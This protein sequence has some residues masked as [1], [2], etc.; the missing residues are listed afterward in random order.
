[1]VRVVCGWFDDSLSIAACR[2]YLRSFL[3]MTRNVAIEE[4]H[5]CTLAASDKG[6]TV[7]S[8]HPCCKA[9]CNCAGIWYGAFGSAKRQLVLRIDLLSQA[10]SSSADVEQQNCIEAFQKCPPALHME[11]RDTSTGNIVHSEF[12]SQAQ[13]QWIW[14]V[15]DEGAVLP[16]RGWWR[17]SF[18]PD[19]E[20][21]TSSTL[22]Y[23]CVEIATHNRV[24]SAPFEVRTKPSEWVLVNGLPSGVDQP[25]ALSA[26]LTACASHGTSKVAQGLD[27]KQVVAVKGP[28]SALFVKLKSRAQAGAVVLGAHALRAVRAQ[29][30]HSAAPPLQSEVLQR[31]LLAP[32]DHTQQPSAFPAASAWSPSGAVLVSHI[33]SMNTAC[34]EDPSLSSIPV[35]ACSERVNIRR[36]YSSASPLGLPSVAKMPVPQLDGPA[37]SPAAL[38]RRPSEDTCSE[39]EGIETG[40]GACHSDDAATASACGGTSSEGWD[41]DACSVSYWDQVAQQLDMQARSTELQ[42]D[43]DEDVVLPAAVAPL[44]PMASLPALP[45]VSSP[46]GACACCRARGVKRVRD[47]D[48]V[49]SVGKASKKRASLNFDLVHSLPRVEDVLGNDHS[50][51]TLVGD[52]LSNA[53]GRPW[54]FHF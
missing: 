18:R 29:Q 19:P 16:A 54:S 45:V 3:L 28:S 37:Q 15:G 25:A 32:S 13:M 44:P 7:R 50:A 39:P 11:Y 27:V 48:D 24:T 26:L 52:E 20:R 8:L 12:V 34:K 2:V 38:E 49:S 46:G 43:D 47:A 4:S 22:A 41:D 17:V 21:L 5:T 51:L 1:M 6:D 23:A 40:S 31:V 53:A 9:D 30:Q 33:P 35:P 14:A 10:A 36:T 42:A